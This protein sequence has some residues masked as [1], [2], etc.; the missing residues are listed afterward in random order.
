[1]KLMDLWFTCGLILGPAH[2]SL[3]IQIHVDFTL[4]YESNSVVM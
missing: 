1:M 3:A 2:N 4:K